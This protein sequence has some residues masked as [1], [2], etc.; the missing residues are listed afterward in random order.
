MNLKRYAA[1]IFILL[2]M[3]FMGRVEEAR[4]LSPAGI[5]LSSDVI[6]QGDVGLI[7]IAVQKG[8]TP[9][10]VWMKQKLLAVPDR[11]GEI[12]EPHQRS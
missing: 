4:A 6:P 9:Q 8:Q 7:E 5:K 11:T 12:T 2:G 1:L 10:I 3:P